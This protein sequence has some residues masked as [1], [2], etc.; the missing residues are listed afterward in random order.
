MAT[1]F[2]PTLIATLEGLLAPGGRA[3]LSN[4]V[5]AAQCEILCGRIP[6]VQRHHEDIRTFVQ[7]AD[8]RIAQLA[9]LWVEFV[10]AGKSFTRSSYAAADFLDAYLA[11]YC[12]TNVAKIQLSLLDV[13]VRE[14]LVGPTLNVIDLGVGTGTTLL[15]L[16]DFLLAWATV[17]DLYG[18]TFPI[19]AVTFTGLDCEARNLTYAHRVAT[20]YAGALRRRRAC[21]TDLMVQTRL[22]AMEAWVATARWQRHDLNQAPYNGDAGNLVIASNVF[23]ELS[24]AGRDHLGDLLAAMQEGGVGI[25]IE[26][27]A[28][29]N[30]QQ[31][32]GW[33]RKLVAR[34]GALTS[35]GPCG[36]EP[37]APMSSACDTCW[38]G[39]RESFHQPLL[40]AHFR[41]HAAKIQ[42][43]N[44]PF[45]DEE[46]QLLSW[47][48]VLLRVAHPV[49]E[50]A[51]PFDAL[52]HGDPWPAT[53]PLTFIGSFRARLDSGI[54]N[55]QIDNP[56]PDTVPVG[57]NSWTEFVKLCPTVVPNVETLSLQRNKG[58]QL[59]RLRYGEVISIT[60]ATTYYPARS[61]VVRIYPGS[62]SR[63]ERIHTLPSL[64]E[65]FLPTYTPQ[66][67][68][69]VDEIAYR[70]FGFPSMRPFQHQIL[71]QSLTGR[72][73][74]G[75]AATGGG[76]SEC[77]ILPAMLLPGITVVV[78]PLKSLMMDQ[79]EQRICQ[80]YGLG[81]LTTI[82]N[83]DIPFV[84][85]QAR[86]Q[87]IELGCYKLVYVTPEQIER[88]YV[89]DSL[90]RADQA[91]GIRY[92]ALDEAH[93]I[94]Q[95]GHDFRS[96]YLNMV[97]RLRSRSI[98]PVR[99]AL[100]ATASPE[101]RHDICDELQLDPRPLEA[102]GNLF[103]ESSNRPELNLVVRVCRTTDEKVEHILSDLRQLH[104]YNRANQ[105]P[106][107]AIV[108]M[109]YTGGKLAY[110]AE[111]GGPERGR[112]SPGA[113]SFASYL[114]RTLR[115]RV[116]I[117]HGKMEGEGDEETQEADTSFKPRQTGPFGDLSGRSRHDQQRAF[118]EGR[119][120][121]MVATKGFG[122]GIDKPNIRWVIHRSAPG[123]LEAYA[124]EAGR[125]GRDGDPA[126]VILYYSPDS[127]MDENAWKQ[128]RLPSDD[129][130][131][132]RF[133]EGKYIR[134]EDVLVLCAFLRSVQRRI[135]GRLYVTND[136]AIAFF[137]RCMQQ[138]QLADLAV[139]YT[140]P[141]WTEREF[142]GNESFDH[143]AILDRGYSYK[144]KTSYVKRILD[145]VYRI[146]PHMGSGSPRESLVQE[147]RESG[148]QLIKPRMKHAKA[149][150]ESNAYFGTVLRDADLS[151]REFTDLL[152]GGDLLKL[153]LR[154]N[155]P[156]SEVVQLVS[157][158]KHL[159]LA[160]S[161]SRGDDMLKYDAL[162]VPHYGPAKGRQSLAD[163]R[164]YA[165]AWRRAKTSKAH[166]RARKAC[167]PINAKGHQ[168]TTLDDWFAWSE[169]NVRQGWEIVTG[170]ALERDQ[171]FSNYLNAF[172]ALHD[173][174]QRNDWAAYH[175]LLTDY[176]GV[177][178]DGTIGQGATHLCLR[179]VLLGYLKTYEVIVG[180]SCLSCSRCVPDENF[181]ASLEA[182]KRVVTHMSAELEHLFGEL[183]RHSIAFPA[184]SLVTALLTTV[185][186]EQRAGH[187]LLAYLQGWTNRVL[188]D[189]PTHRGALVVRT[190]MMLDGLVEVR[191]TDLL[192]LIQNLV[193]FAT[194]D[195]VDAVTALVAQ[196]WHTQPDSST[197]CRQR[198]TLARRQAH[199]VA[200]AQAWEDLLRLLER[201][202]HVQ[203]ASMFEACAALADLY[204]GDPPLHDHVRHAHYTLRAARTARD[205]VSAEQLYQRIIPT[206]TWLELEALAR[207]EYVVG[208]LGLEP[209]VLLKL[210][211]AGDPQVRALPIV[212]AL[213]QD[214]LRWA[215]WP[216]E[217]LRDI[218][219]QLPDVVLGMNPALTLRLISRLEAPIDRLR[220]G[221][222]ALAAEA[223]MTVDHVQFI[224]PA[225]L[226]CAPTD[227]AL[228]TA[229]GRTEGLRGAVYQALR[230][231]FQIEAWD[232]AA[233]LLTQFNAELLTDTPEERLRRLRESVSTLPADAHRQ[234]AAQ[235]LQPLAMPLLTEPTFSSEAHALWQQAC[236]GCVSL[237]IE[238]LGM[239]QRQPETARHALELLDLLAEHDQATRRAMYSELKRRWVIKTWRS[240]QIW[241]AWFTPEICA[242]QPEERVRLVHAWG[243][244]LTADAPSS[245]LIPALSPLIMPLFGDPV[246]GEA[247]HGVWQ[248]LCFTMPKAIAD[249]VSYCDEAHIDEISVS[250]FLTALL[251]H[252]PDTHRAVYLQLR[253]IA[254]QGSSTTTFQRWCCRFMHELHTEELPQRISVL[255][256]SIDLLLAEGE[257]VVIPAWLQ[258]QAAELIAA[259][260]P[261]EWHAT[262]QA[263]ARGSV[264]A[265][266]SYTLL[267]LVISQERTQL[268]DL[269]RSLE[270]SQCAIRQM[271]YRME[272]LVG[273]P[274]NWDALAAWVECWI[275]EICRESFDEQVKLIDHALRFL[276]TDERRTTALA[277]LS[278]PLRVLVRNADYLVEGEL[279]RLQAQIPELDDLVYQ[280][281]DLS[282][283][284][285]TPYLL[286]AWLLRHLSRIQAEPPEQRLGLLA[287]YSAAIPKQDALR[288]TIAERLQPVAISLFTVADLEIVATAHRLWQT[289]CEKLPALSESYV[290]AAVALPSGSPRDRFFDLLPSTPQWL[291]ILYTV[292]K[293]SFSPQCWEDLVVWLDRFATIEATLPDE[294]RLALLRLGI[295]LLSGASEQTAG[296]ARLQVVAQT[297]YRI[298]HIAVQAHQCWQ[299]FI[300][301]KPEAAWSYLKD[302][303]TTPD[304]AVIA[305]HYVAWLTE[306]SPTTWHHIYAHR[307][308]RLMKLH[309]P[310][311]LL[312]AVRWFAPLL[313]ADPP[314]RDSLFIRAVTLAERE[315]SVQPYQT[316]WFQPLVAQLCGEEQDSGASQPASKAAAIQCFANLALRLASKPEEAQAAQ[317]V[318]QAW[319][320][321]DPSLLPF[322]V[323]TFQNQGARSELDGIL[324]HLLNRKQVQVIGGLPPCPVSPRWEQ[325]RQ[326]V[327]ALVQLRL[328]G[329]LTT[330]RLPDR[331]LEELGTCFRPWAD[332]E[333]ADMLVAVLAQIRTWTTPGF[334][335]PLSRQVE[336]LVA[337]GRVASARR[338]ATTRTELTL[339]RRKEPIEAFLRTVAA[340]VDDDRP[341]NPD[342]ARIATQLLGT[343]PQLVR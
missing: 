176:V 291:H 54:W 129:E 164:N 255:Q 309:T 192:T 122:M 16:M 91:V 179:G 156:L 306:H 166:E 322:L 248:R 305:D 71:G 150:L 147:Y 101:V 106:G 148:T 161:G 273:P 141:E 163:W 329:T 332:R 57:S 132:R 102:G 271:V 295:T 252:Q 61:R 266:R 202:E 5:E 236:I 334:L 105:A 278:A 215:H 138:P 199:V 7:A 171:D 165:G 85:R 193:Q 174:R 186:R 139:P 133:L 144:Q 94:S 30:A 269:V 83:G 8:R 38:N 298:P 125:A 113:S 2:D 124:Q 24:E 116:A 188:L 197:I 180:E 168:E 31:L 247:A 272:K 221:R 17:C 294:E 149:I 253:P 198:I 177:E 26:P 135:V 230:T 80:R 14:A 319:M 223:V 243:A 172:M 142:E 107:A 191:R 93:C 10:R 6:D 245:Q 112:R 42:L 96:S 331:Y 325:A 286:S 277:L 328:L 19:H 40:Y 185:R 178:T 187:S 151:E 100:T 203:Q 227:L 143:G 311:D 169:V 81:N 111:D 301:A 219:R 249:Y 60:N 237:A 99:I 4:Y 218:V 326:F 108:F 11:Y 146:R 73:I 25:V 27:G 310:D 76:K 15:G 250:R 206:Q 69:A 23:N 313:R 283:I 190:T 257:R 242:E 216:A 88:G 152:T 82:I 318:W 74:L 234:A 238:Y 229:L 77:Y 201:K 18:V 210:W 211:L 287:R 181:T 342:Y 299:Q 137:D 279:D 240:L 84:E 58:I 320:V 256:R 213:A 183:D 222:I 13:V 32:M 263:E 87:R 72:S 90:R 55:T 109:P 258:T 195:D 36:S 341:L 115:D 29:Q 314:L 65:T 98:H 63:V 224:A 300:Q 343:G 160:T 117:Y 68:R 194:D 259:P 127:P 270:A 212:A 162:A 312:R 52:T 184:P 170:P 103:I 285:N 200:E 220:M 204:G 339:G 86:L 296:V 157:D 78:S 1:P 104:A 95:W 134:R 335:T 217:E 173:S 66:V 53:Q 208:W 22:Q 28:K 119:H 56:E 39:R 75:I 35:I 70:L 244:L 47:S 48:Y 167:R 282:I 261:P 274:A 225:A 228:L 155:Q 254:L 321:A 276:P 120:A 316:A 97:Q 121:I 315:R 20:A 297:L 131:Q 159:Q 37:S 264:A 281:E 114:E 280:S 290:T 9:Q 302:C 44:R 214:R 330:G 241:L 288:M 140:W 284:T 239:N 67:Q 118:I 327:K 126:T 275:D 158:I 92:L 338:L 235:Q 333:Q 59:P 246:V 12:T 268:A 292:L 128:K 337:G 317:R 3:R 110:T 130:I 304:G 323:Q 265:A 21:S 153:A 51:V 123:N 307:Q 262:L 232:A 41:K 64:A 209:P 336:A 205:R 154:L 175:R 43:D 233:W 293:P 207:E 62:E 89:L 324:D 33:R 260:L 45:D 340:P 34:S 189:T 49:S 267:C 196:A 50:P 79:Y 226:Q 289:V 303:L 136:E 46:N 182:R 251:T 308:P 231:H 145:V